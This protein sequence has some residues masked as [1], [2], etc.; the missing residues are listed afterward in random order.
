M[1]ERSGCLS[2]QKNFIFLLLFLGIASANCRGQGFPFSIGA[3]SWGT[4]N[5]TV[6]RADFTSGFTNIAGLGGLHEA[7]IFSSFDSHYG[8]E[9]I[10]TYS[11][12][13]VLP[14]SEDLGLGFTVQRFGDKLYSESA[15][16]LGAGHRIGRVSLGLKVNYL[17]NAVN[18]P[19]LSF[20]R[21]ALVFEFGGIMQL[22]SQ[23]FFG[24]HVFNMTQSSY[25]GDY[26]G[27]V[28][29]ALRTGFLYKPQT[30]IL[31]SAELEKNTNLP[32]SIKAGLEYQVWKKLF[33]RTGVASRPLTNHF[34]A[35]FKAKKILIDYAVHSNSQLGWSHHFSV[36]Y[37]FWNRK[38]E[39]LNGVN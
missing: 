18:A 2:Q 37:V 16:G 32:V 7:G 19:T 23:L 12:G 25:S 22:S 8:F 39:E 35:G 26:G 1:K 13:A 11:F 20:N 34:G 36:G 31:F 30:N 24:A 21:N 27:R 17:Q 4:G 10:G 9:G 28:P 29:T 3:R 14:L 33:L 5:A 15:M 38:N 6:A